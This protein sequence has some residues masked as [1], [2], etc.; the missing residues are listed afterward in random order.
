MRRL[1]SLFMAG[2]AVEEARMGRSSKATAFMFN[3][4]LMM[5]LTDSQ[6]LFSVF[7]HHSPGIL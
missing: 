1:T 4:M 5:Q 7:F 6:D 3:F 2:D